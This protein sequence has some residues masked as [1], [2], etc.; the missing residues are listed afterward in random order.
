MP[1]H[2]MPFSKGIRYPTTWEVVWR[3]GDESACTWSRDPHKMSHDD[4]DRLALR[5]IEAGRKAMV[6]S[7][8]Q[9]DTIGMPVG[10][11]PGSVDWE[12]DVIH[13]SSVVTMWSRNHA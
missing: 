3:A 9:L 4:A 8:R 5:H 7:T 13:Y 10:W 6:I 11:E 12:Q 2:K 1:A